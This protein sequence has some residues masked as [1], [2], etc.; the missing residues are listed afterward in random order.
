MFRLGGAYQIDD[1][2]LRAGL[3]YDISPVPDR[4]V[5]ATLP[6]N[7]RLIWTLGAGYSFGM[8]RVDLAYMNLWVFGRELP[9]EG[10]NVPVNSAPGTYD[11]GFVHLLS[12]SVGV[13][14]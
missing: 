5:D 13:R 10:E 1:L 2:T 4:T 8:L 9:T 6:D 12:A 3:A 11:G 7:D 14:I